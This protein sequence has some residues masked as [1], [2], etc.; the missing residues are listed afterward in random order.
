MPDPGHGCAPVR[1]IR[2][3]GNSWQTRARTAL[4]VPVAVWLSACYTV[5]FHPVPP[6]ALPDR[7]PVGVSLHVPEEVAQA[8]YSFRA[9]GSGIANRWTVPY[10]ARLQ[11]FARAF[12][13]AAASSC[14]DATSPDDV[15]ENELL[16]RI[17]RADYR[18]E[19][20]AAHVRMRVDAVDGSGSAVLGKEYAT[21]GLGGLGSVALG[22]AFVQKSVTRS[23]TDAAFREIF[24]ALVGDLERGWNERGVVPT[25][26]SLG[27][28]RSGR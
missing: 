16:V 14:R 26:G 15:G 8:T 20:Q 19:G 22:G 6:P 24:V 10:G 1:A 27:R 2:R 13:C 7:I 12:L 17:E 25:T 23:S 28:L 5:G 9:F 18:V 3:E 21:R 11:E 4:L